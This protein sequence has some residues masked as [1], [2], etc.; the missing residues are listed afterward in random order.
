[1]KI[2]IQTG[3]SFFFNSI[4]FSD[5]FILF[6]RFVKKIMK[7]ALNFKIHLSFSL[8]FYIYNEWLR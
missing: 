3:I 2:F 8:L 7:L 4:R 5:Y 6:S 1:M